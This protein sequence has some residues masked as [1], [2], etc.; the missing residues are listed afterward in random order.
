M[1]T[2]ACLTYIID[3]VSTVQGHP[4]HYFPGTGVLQANA[5][6]DGA[7]QLDK[8]CRENQEELKNLLLKRLRKMFPEVDEDAL[9]PVEDI[10]C[11]RW[12][13][14]QN[15]GGA[16]FQFGPDATPA[17]FKALF[18]DQGNLIFSG[19]AACRRYYGFAHGAFLTGRRD[20]NRILQKINDL[21]GS[22]TSYEV[23]LET[24]CEDLPSN[25]DGMFGGR[26]RPGKK[27]QRGG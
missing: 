24:R 5:G 2:A 19:E 4:V 20:A 6:G 14:M 9:E 26:F 23:N 12:S 22:S 8:M 10:V 21:E 1:G 16:W 3:A 27:R 17:D 7:I 11:T 25:N 13:N 18:Q 15:F